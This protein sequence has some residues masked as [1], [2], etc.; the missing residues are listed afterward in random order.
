MPNGLAQSGPVPS[1][2]AATNWLNAAQWGV[3]NQGQMAEYQSPPVTTASAWNAAVSAFDTDGVANQL[4]RMGVGYLI[5]CIGQNSGYYCS[6][7]AT[8]DSIVG[9][10]PSHCSTRDLVAD[11]Y[12]SLNARGIGLMVYLPSGAP[13]NDSQAVAA[14]QWHNDTDG[15][16]LADFQVMWQNIITEWSER[17]GSK[18]Q[19]WWFDGVVYGSAMY[20]F[21]SPP[22]W[23][24]FAAAARSGN[25]T[26]IIA[27]NNG[28][29]NPIDAV[30]P[31]EDYTAGEENYGALG[32]FSNSRWMTAPADATE[33]A[34]SQV[35]TH[36]LTFAGSWWA[37]GNSPYNTTPQLI[38]ATNS[39]VNPGGAFTWDMP[40]INP[41]GLIEPAFESPFTT[42]AD[43][44]LGRYIVNDTSSTITYGGGT[45]TYSSG[46]GVGDYDDDVH[47]TTANGAYAQFTFNGSG[48]QILS[49]RDSDMGNVQIYLDGTLMITYDC[50][51]TGGKRTRQ[52]IYEVKGL[53]SGS[54]SVKLVKVDGSYA[55]LD[56][57]R[58][59]SQLQA[60]VNDNDPT[61]SYVGSSWRSD[62]GRNV[63]D[64]NQDVHFTTNVGD[65]FSYTFT[66]TGIQYIT[67]N[68][69]DM[70][71]VQIYLDGVSQG[72]YNCYASGGKVTQQPVF[73]SLGLTH[74]SHTI[75]V[76]MVSGA[77]CILDCLRV[78]A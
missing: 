45:W 41:S 36:V 77:Y 57:Y 55:I 46:R 62:T 51:L 61:I 5:H 50:Y 68:D 21:A 52:V 75:K 24:S 65:Y 59:L 26:S 11:L 60:V 64:Y 23:D 33:G 14:L 71:N 17:W 47:F 2:G 38:S 8:Y 15:Q 49:E 25:R 39:I 29:N 53:A 58:V 37:Q 6:P 42:V 3:F 40:L 18:V 66:G 70:G 44:L 16:R 34:N 35:M 73:T 56:A 10:S 31:Q 22:N 74:G 69:T 72:T 54:H 78:Y 1:G 63:T 30:A 13:Q 67:E 48:V 7:N 19:G 4:Q 28:P 9:Y 43:Q 76:Q 12:T 20:N 27:F 32:I